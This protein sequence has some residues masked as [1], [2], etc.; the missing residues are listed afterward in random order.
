M[1]LASHRSRASSS[2]FQTGLKPSRWCGFPSSSEL[3]FNIKVICSNRNKSETPRNTPIELDMS[4]TPSVACLPK[5]AIITGASSGMPESDPL[6]LFETCHYPRKSIVGIGKATAIAF[7]EAGW[8]LSLIAR[9]V[10]KLQE[11]KQLCKDP[12]KVLLLEGDISNEDDVL[13]LFRGTIERFGTSTPSLIMRC[14]YHIDDILRL[15]QDI[16]MCSS[17]C[18]C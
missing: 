4:Q 8:S 13:R 10:D 12:A 15:P 14:G 2:P 11:T 5:V 1:V 16:W 9:R 18:V 7:A 6:N 17:M 3:Q